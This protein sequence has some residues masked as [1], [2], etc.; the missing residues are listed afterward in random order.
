M[1]HWFDR[2][3]KVL[4]RG[5][6][7][8]REALKG[9][10]LTGIAS[11]LPS[12][13][14]AEAAPSPPGNISG[15]PSP[16]G[17]ISTI[18]GGVAGNAPPLAAPAP[19]TRTNVG[20][21]RTITVSALANYKGQALSLRSVLTTFGSLSQG[22]FYQRVDLG[23]KLLSELS[24][25]FT[26]GFRRPSGGGTTPAAV[27]VLWAEIRQG[28]PIR[29]PSHII[30]KATD[31]AFQGFADGH[32]I[33]QRT[34]PIIAIEPDLQSSMQLLFANARSNLDLCGVGAQRELTAPTASDDCDL[35]H[36]KCNIAA[37]GGVAGAG[38]LLAGDVPGALLAWGGAWLGDQICEHNCNKPGGP[39][40]SVS[41]GDDFCCGDGQFC[42][43]PQ[44]NPNGPACCDNGAVC[45]SVT[46]P[47]YGPISYCC[48]AGSDSNGCLG[49][50][51]L[52][53]TH[54]CHQPGEVCCGDWACV[55]G[56]FCAYPSFDLCCSEGQSACAGLCCSGKCFTYNAGTSAQFQQ[57]C[58]PDSVCGDSCCS[59]NEHC[60]TS[61]TGAK[62]CCDQ[63]TLCGE[64]CCSGGATCSNGRCG[65]GEPCGNA[66]CGFAKCC[67]GVCCHFN[68]TCVNGKCTPPACPPGQMPCPVTPNQC[69]PPG[70]QCCV[71]NACCDPSTTECCGGRGCVPRGTCIQ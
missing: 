62:V 71:N 24:L 66:F 1:E 35:C 13:S 60:L 40:C 16:P 33:D 69:C 43:G 45:T 8:R 59:P 2:A 70:L 20:G 38:Q 39:C 4:A 55:K 27:A 58:S 26:T 63:P 17:N 25:R 23:S 19:C 47:L 14:W 12:A 22:T 44:S 46:D 50:N 56:Q 37:S 11:I 65:F 9:F 51:P 52:A 31:S 21:K 30:L 42:C 36:S 54:Y 64:V 49:G 29:G 68:E 61:S 53:Y 28:P 34:P 3:T 41:C 6:A 10:A 18:L 7:S 15:A 32:P 5:E 67:D 48:P 57:C